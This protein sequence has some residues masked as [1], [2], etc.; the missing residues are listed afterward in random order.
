MPSPCD[1]TFRFIAPFRVDSANPR[2]WVTGGQYV[3]ETSKGF[4]TTCSATA[5]NWKQV[6]DAGAGSSITAINAN[7]ATIYAGWCSG[8]CNPASASTTDTGFVRGAATNYG[9]AWHT[10]GADLPNGYINQLIIDPSNPAHVHALLG[11][12][13]RRW[14]PNAGVGHVFESTSGGASFTDISGN[15]PGTVADDLLITKSGKLVVATD[16]G[17][18]VT[19]EA[20]P[21]SYTRL[22]GLPNSAV[23]D[24]SY[25]SGQAYIIAATHGRGLPVDRRMTRGDGRGTP[26]PCEERR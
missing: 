14:I 18:F 25:G 24:L 6:Y 19:P 8:A 7:G 26:F 22:G 11:G 10:I 13:S 17:V 16:V 3:W 2:H 9:G 20:S 15:M 23:N 1:P 21:G 12:Y 5:C 4:D